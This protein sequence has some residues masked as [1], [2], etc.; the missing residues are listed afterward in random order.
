MCF[1]SHRPGVADAK[2]GHQK[3]SSVVIAKAGSAFRTAWP[4]TAVGLAVAANGVWI[5]AFGYGFSRIL[6]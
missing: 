4:L 5:A 1:S 6:Y 3:G 2:R